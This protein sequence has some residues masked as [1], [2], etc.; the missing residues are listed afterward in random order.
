M[1]LRFK[2]HYKLL[3]L[4]VMASA[5]LIAGAGD[6]RIIAYSMP[7]GEQVAEQAISESSGASFPEE[8]APAGIQTLVLDAAHDVLDI[9]NE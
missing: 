2:R 1:S 7:A 4:L 6:E 9:G 8:P 3:V 5:V